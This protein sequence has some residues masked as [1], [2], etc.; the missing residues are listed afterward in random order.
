MMLRSI[1]NTLLG[2]KE[3]MRLRHSSLTQMIAL[4]S[5]YISRK[6]NIPNNMQKRKYYKNFAHKKRTIPSRNHI[7]C[8]IFG[9]TLGISLYNIAYGYIP[10][11]D[12]VKA[13]AVEVVSENCEKKDE[14][15]NIAEQDDQKK[16]KEKKEKT[17]F[18]DRKVE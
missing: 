15:V 7:F 9:S 18:R 13:E 1:I 14:S 6:I 4:R 16:K 12:N 17:G 11:N 8:L 5:L 3:G 2:R 10:F